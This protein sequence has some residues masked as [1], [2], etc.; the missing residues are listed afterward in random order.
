MMD[1]YTFT[2]ESNESAPII[3]KTNENQYTEAE[4]ILLKHEVFGN[5]EKS[6]WCR[7]A[8]SFQ[9]R[10]LLA[11]KQ[12]KQRPKRPLTIQDLLYIYSIK[13]SPYQPNEQTTITTQNYEIFWNWFGPVL[14]RIRYQ[15][16]LLI[17]WLSGL[18]CG[19]VSKVESE[20]ILENATRGAFIIRFSEQRAGELAI[21]YIPI[22]ES[23]DLRNSPS[24]TTGTGKVR[25][26]LLQ[27][28][29]IYA[30][31][32]TLPDFLGKCYNLSH[33]VQVFY[34]PQRGRVYQQIPKDLVLGEYYSKMGKQDTVDGYEK[35]L[36]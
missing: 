15:R 32:K 2:I 25:H 11:T 33:I 23:N 17:L 29:D 31:K 34:D 19:F 27:A 24:V 1:N 10:Y 28:D 35:Q 20:K 9:K 3:V 6:T 7:F 4:G 36:M 22:D 14:Y 21:A 16:H 30:A 18:I 8:N 12:E 13:F 5:Y 26:Y